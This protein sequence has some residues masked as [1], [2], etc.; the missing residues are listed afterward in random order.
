[1]TLWKLNIKTDIV[2]LLLLVTLQPVTAF[3]QN[4][5]LICLPIK[6]FDRTII[7]LQELDY[8]RERSVLD[9][10]M[11]HLLQDENA[12]LYQS[13][14]YADSALAQESAKSSA[15]SKQLNQVEKEKRWWQMGTGAA[16]LLLIL[17]VLI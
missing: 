16:T 3:S 13:N 2:C 8:L 10:T 5:S 15:Y 1:M 9:S 7:E 6:A 4:D 17:S 14:Q 12:L 11:L